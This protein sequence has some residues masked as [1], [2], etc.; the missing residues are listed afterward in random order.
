MPHRLPRPDTCSASRPMGKPGALVG[1]L[2][3][4]AALCAEALKALL[5]PRYGG[6]RRAVRSKSA[7]TKSCSGGVSEYQ[8]VGNT[9]GGRFSIFRAVL[10]ICTKY[11]VHP[12]LLL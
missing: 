2:W 7:I 10:T 5:I 9:I 4:F 11:C 1:S 3:M 6:N 12:G 8:F